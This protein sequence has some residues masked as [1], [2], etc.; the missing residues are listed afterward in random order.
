MGY[1]YFFCYNCV[2]LCLLGKIAMI[3]L[4]AATRWSLRMTR[5][6][7][8]ESLVERECC[9][10]RKFRVG[11]LWSPL[12][13][14]GDG[15]VPANGLKVHWVSR[16]VEGPNKLQQ[17]VKY[18]EVV[19][20]SRILSISLAQCYKELQVP[21]RERECRRKERVGRG[22]KEGCTTILHRR[23]TIRSRIELD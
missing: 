6:T 13:G 4:L 7:K 15:P 10:R 12:T 5:F 22:L 23:Q 11:V 17:V 20:S 8:K 9:G 19:F 1:Y 2:R 3:N 18:Y 16:C 14:L 21:N